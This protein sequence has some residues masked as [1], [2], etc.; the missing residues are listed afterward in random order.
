MLTF[1]VTCQRTTYF[2]QVA[3][4]CQGLFK[5]MLLYF[6]TLLNKKADKT[7]LKTSWVFSRNSKMLFPTFTSTVKCYCRLPHSDVAAN[8]SIFF[9]ACMA[10]KA[11]LLQMSKPSNILWNTDV[12]RSNFK[13]KGFEVY[14]VLSES[15]D[16]IFQ[17][18]Y[19]HTRAV[20]SDVSV[21]TSFS[22]NNQS[23]MSE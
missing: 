18:F 22:S 12:F 5:H 23:P 16:C 17:T 15:C 7:A 2:Y 20:N 1:N 19:I 9:G 11:D 14:Y 13:T 4:K 8:V 3:F 21:K 10:L 6:N